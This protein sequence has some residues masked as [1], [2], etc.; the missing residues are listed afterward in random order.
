MPTIVNIRSQAMRHIP[1]EELHAYLDQ[2]LSR[3]QCVEI[4][5]HLAGCHQCREA[6]DGIAALRD[7]TTALLSTLA[8]AR[9]IPPPFDEIRRQQAASSEVHRHR[10][11]LAIWAASVVAAVSLGWGANTIAHNREPAVATNPQASH[12]LAQQ[13]P[14]PVR[15]SATADTTTPPQK[16]ATPEPRRPSTLAQNSAPAHHELA[17]PEPAAKAPAPT[18]S[19]Q[20]PREPSLTQVSSSNLPPDPDLDLQGLWRTVGW[21]YAR[22][23][24]GEAPPHI[25]G[26]PVMQVQVQGGDQ[27]GKPVMVVAQQLKSGEVIRTIEGPAD[28]VTGLLGKRV[29]R[30]SDTAAL[31]TSGRSGLA[32]HATSGTMTMRR[33]DRIL[34][35]TAPLP[36]DSLRAMIRRLN[37]ELRTN[38]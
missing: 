25:D 11:Q 1:E 18:S 28:E 35:I 32:I 19:R 5:S 20:F 38:R 24:A 7:R 10:V 26:L 6:R 2:A 3:S 34:A 12:Q 31:G 15:D 29:G 21:E 9:R 27:G 17:A 22:D 16:V 36:S 23:S 30:Q 33:G 14:A 4:E 13:Y 8:P 37:A